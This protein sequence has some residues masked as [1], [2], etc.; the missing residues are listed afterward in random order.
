[1]H[2]LSDSQKEYSQEENARRYIRLGETS[3]TGSK[4]IIRIYSEHGCNFQVT[5]KSIKRETTISYLTMFYH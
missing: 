4:K 5:K 3:K 1:M 2:C